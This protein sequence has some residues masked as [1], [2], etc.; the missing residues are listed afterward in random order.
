M[1]SLLKRD[2]TQLKLLLQD[3]EVFASE[4]NDP[5]NPTFTAE[6]LFF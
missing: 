2:E 3:D 4:E 1:E 6:R 5:R